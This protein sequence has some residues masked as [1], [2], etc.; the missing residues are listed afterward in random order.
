MKKQVRSFPSQRD[1]I[2]ECVLTYYVD[3]SKTVISLDS[4]FM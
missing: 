1:L 2:K 3:A 4:T